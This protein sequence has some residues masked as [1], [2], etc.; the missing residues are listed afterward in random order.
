MKDCVILIHLY[1]GDCFTMYACISFFCKRYENIHIFSLERNAEFIK[2]LYKNMNVNI[3]VIPK[4]EHAKSKLAYAAPESYIKK[5]MKLKEYDLIKTGSSFSDDGKICNEWINYKKIIKNFWRIFYKQAGL[6]YDIRYN[7]M[8]INRNIEKE[9]EFYNKIVAIYGQKYIFLH[10]HRNIN[11]KHTRNRFTKGLYIDDNIPV[12]HP[13]I[14]YYEGE[15]KYSNL[16]K[17][18]LISD[19]ILDYGMIM[20]NAFIIDIVDSSFCCFSPYLNLSKVSKKIVRT[21]LDIQDYHKNFNDW[22]ITKFI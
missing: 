7:F 18:E 9:K 1:T 10:D 22:V 13:N 20:E 11:G 8:K 3:T 4:D 17:P 14:N 21:D 16:W 19:N 5:Y 15:H 2:Q 12:F 6:D